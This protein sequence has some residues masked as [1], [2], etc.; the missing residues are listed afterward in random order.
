MS[1][2]IEGGVT[3]ARGFFR[4]GDPLRHPEKP[5]Q[6]GPGPDFLRPA[7]GSGGGVYPELGQGCSPDRDETA[8]GKRHRPRHRVQQRD[9]QHLRRRR[10]ETAEE[11][12][13]L[14]AEALGVDVMDVLPAST[15]VIG[16]SLPL[17][18]IAAAMPAL[19]AALSETGSSEAAEAIMTT[20]TVKRSLP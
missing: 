12:C 15:G 16:P 18:P 9:R 7:S 20:D 8:S 19:A 10:I 3:A 11:M 17:A 13:R 6:K 5:E 1:T 4:R 14:A 2:F